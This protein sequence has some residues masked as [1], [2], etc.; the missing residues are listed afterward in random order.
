MKVKVLRNTVAR[1]ADKGQ[2]MTVLAGKT[3]DVWPAD[4]QLLVRM[5]YAEG[6]EGPKRKLQIKYVSPD[7]G[8]E[9][10]PKK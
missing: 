3:Y 8:A 6:I 1:D 4:A 5:G 7:V 2:P 10:R 9:K